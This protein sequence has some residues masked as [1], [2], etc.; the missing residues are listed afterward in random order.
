M[1]PTIENKFWLA[2]AENSKLRAL[3]ERWWRLVESWLLWPLSQFDAETCTRPVL[4][5]LA[6]QRDITRGKNE[7]L[8]LYRLRVKWACVNAQDAGSTAG[9]ARIFQRLELGAVM[10][11]ERNAG[12]DWDIVLLQLND[13][14]IASNHDLLDFIIRQYGRTCRRYQFQTI[15]P[16]AFSVYATEFNC[17]WQVF[18]AVHPT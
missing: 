5:L 6:W 14:Q 1:L 8:R 13:S 2:G 15:T 12:M 18:T 11:K 9:F 3:A 7:P 17:D 10:I 4:D 16:M